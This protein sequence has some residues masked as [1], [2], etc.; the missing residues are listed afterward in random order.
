MERIFFF[1]GS[2]QEVSGQCGGASMRMRQS[3]TIFAGGKGFALP[4]L[5]FQNGGDLVSTAQEG[6]GGI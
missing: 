2:A 3:K 1:G 4:R 6:A 5:L